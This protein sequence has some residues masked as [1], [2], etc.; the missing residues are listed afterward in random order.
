M[1]A[2]LIAALILA[3]CGDD[4]KYAVEKLQ[5]PNTCLDCHA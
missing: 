3:A 5:D 4:A 2:L 1:K